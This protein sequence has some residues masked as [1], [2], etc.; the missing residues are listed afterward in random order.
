MVIKF[1]IKSG[2]SGHLNHQHVH[3]G[4][5]EFLKNQNEIVGFQLL[6]SSIFRKYMGLLN[7][8]I[9]FFT[10]EDQDTFTFFSPNLLDAF[11]AMKCYQSQFVWFRKL[12]IL[13]SQY[14]YINV[15][16]KMK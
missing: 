14:S 7:V 3:D 2:I 5:V 6:S 15:L 1:P 8:I 13:F 9:W 11:K 12:F 10:L 16:Q 4:C